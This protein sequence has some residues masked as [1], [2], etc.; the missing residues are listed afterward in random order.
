MALSS[1]I[2]YTSKQLLADIE[3]DLST[4]QVDRSDRHTQS[5]LR[6]I[7]NWLTR[8]RTKATDTNLKSIE[9]LLQSF[10]H[11]CELA[12]WAQAVKIY[13]VT[14]DTPTSEPLYNQLDTW[15]YFSTQKALAEKLL[16]HVQPSAQPALLTTLGNAYASLSHYNQAIDYHQ[17]SLILARTLGDR[18]AEEQALGNFGGLL[19]NLGKYEAATAA[20]QSRLAL[21][22]LHNNL[23]GESHAL[24]NLGL[25][26]QARGDLAKA[27]E[28]HQRSIAIAK[29]RS[30]PSNHI[31]PEQQALYK[32]A[33]GTALNNLGIAYFSQGYFDQAFTCHQKRLSLATALGDRPAQMKTLGNLGNTLLALG[34]VEQAISILNQ[35]LTLATEI[36]D[37]QLQ[38]YAN[39]S[40]GTAHAR[41]NQYRQAV[42]YHQRH[43]HTAQTIQDYGGQEQALNNLC[44]AYTALDIPE[45]VIKYGQQ[46]LAILNQEQNQSK[47]MDTLARLSRAHQKLAQQTLTPPDASGLHYRQAVDYSQQHLAIAERTHN[48][49]EAITALLSLGRIDYSQQRYAHAHQHQTKALEKAQNLNNSKLV[50][51][52]LWD[53]GITCDARLDFAEAI[54]CYQQQLQLEKDRHEDSTPTHLAVL[55]NLGEAYLSSQLYSKALSCFQQRLAL[56]RVLGAQLSTL[57]SL[58][59]LGYVFFQ[60]NQP[61]QALAQYQQAVHVAREINNATA[62]AE[63]L[64]NLGIGFFQQ[65]QIAAARKSWQDALEIAQS[66][67]LM[68]LETACLQSLRE[69]GQRKQR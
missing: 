43:L 56:S 51:N 54:D 59:S 46:H 19:Y 63:A 53:L 41:L 4:K 61:Q 25:I 49:A 14:L 5:Q 68:T 32:Q 11:L 9:G 69:S 24:T 21:A 23:L 34:D 37:Y 12:A 45:K 55:N 8:H 17:K 27:V 40:L 1:S 31:S 64:Y 20:H 26:F 50:C 22:Q 52:C 44:G 3:A 10:Y 15:G 42:T 67:K 36:G 7:S 29:E 47:A 66:L 2:I 39:G 48:Q 62:E 60:L 30:R 33:E 13:E 18:Q 65:S 57:Q 35:C 6:A 16:P 58:N 28:H 38:G